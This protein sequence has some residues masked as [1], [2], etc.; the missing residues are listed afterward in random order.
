MNTL[1]SPEQVEEIMIELRNETPMHVIA[2]DFSISRAMI[3]GIN[4]GRWK[5]YRLDGVSYPVVDKKHQRMLEDREHRNRD[6]PEAPY[7]LHSPLD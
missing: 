6:N 2:K 1:L 3:Q 4:E 7:I 5:V